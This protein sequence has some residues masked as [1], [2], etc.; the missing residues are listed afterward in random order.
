VADVGVFSGTLIQFE[1]FGNH[2]AFRLLN[3]YRDRVCAF[4]DDTQGTASVA[5]AGML[6]AMR[7]LDQKLVDQKILFPGAGKTCTGI[8]DLIASAMTSAG[9]GREEARLRCWFTD[10]KGLVVKN[11]QRLAEHKLPC[12]HDF[13]HQADIVEVTVRC[14]H[15]TDEMFLAA[16]RVLAEEVSGE[17]F[18]RGSAYPPLRH[19]R[20]IPLKIAPAVAELAFEQVLA[21]IKRPE[22]LEGLIQSQVFEPN[23]RS[24]E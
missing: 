23:Y 7:M 4:N 10:S 18:E 15:V 1:D 2:Y 24:Y 21:G 8:G 3:R 5:L 9:L 6:A 20:E 17:D 12:A 16:S 22:N 14:R 11:R 19:I 13:E